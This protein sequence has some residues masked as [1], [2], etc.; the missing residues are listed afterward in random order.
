LL[1]CR[2]LAVVDDVY[3]ICV[4]MLENLAMLR[5]RYGLGKSVHEVELIIEMYR[6]L[7]DRGGYSADQ[8]IGELAGSFAF[9]LFDN[10]MRKLLV[11]SVSN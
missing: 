1:A 8:V 5:Q 7:R 2:T 6:S 10:K 11:A 4:G 3:C 9:V